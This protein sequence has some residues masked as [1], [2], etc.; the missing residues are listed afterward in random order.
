[1]LRVDGCLGTRHD[2]APARG[3]GHL[4]RELFNKELLP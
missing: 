3:V 2:D 4:C 1:M